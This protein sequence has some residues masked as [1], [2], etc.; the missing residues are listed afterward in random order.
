MQILCSTGTFSRSSDPAS[1]QAILTYGP[2][3]AVDGLEVIFYPQWYPD[4]ERIVGMLRT[5]G[6]KFPVLHLDKRIGGAFGN[7]NP[8]E[9]EQGVSWF[10]QNCAFA[11][12]IGACIAVL[13]LW[14]MPHVDTHLEHN[15]RPLTRCL[16]IAEQYRLE[17]AIETIPC[18]SS[19]PLSNVKR[20]CEHD[21][22]SRIAL[23]SEF[24]AIHNQLDDVFEATWLWQAG[25]VGHVHLKDYDGNPFLE[26]GRRYLHLGEGQIDFGRFV[27]QLRAGGFDGGL[28]LESRAIDNEGRVDVARIQASLQLVRHLAGES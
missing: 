25:L 17:L 2:Q 12:Q 27:R 16:D 22:R 7:S 6:L 11:Q 5:C 23:D 3:L 19:D 24:L 15:L 20:A 4:Q 28:S 1:Y 18:T 8:A 10:E 14:G 26:G 21:A 13:H 9:Q